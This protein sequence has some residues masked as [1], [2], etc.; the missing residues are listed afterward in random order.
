[1]TYQRWE[2]QQ[3]EEG[4][5]QPREYYGCWCPR[6]IFEMLAAFLP[7]I[8][9]FAFGRH[10]LYPIAVLLVFILLVLYWVYKREKSSGQ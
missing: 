10:D 1:M 9:A 4:E 3:Q 7:V 5:L 8:L 6:A 2:D